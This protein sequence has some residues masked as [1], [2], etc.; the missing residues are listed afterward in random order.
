MNILGIHFGHDAGVCVLVPGKRP[1]AVGLERLDRIKYSGSYTRGWRNHF[2][3]NLLLLVDYCI[4]GAELACEDSKFDYIIYTKPP[5]EDIAFRSLLSPYTKP[6]TLFSR[7]NH[8]IAHACS[9][10]FASPFDDAAV[11]VVDG[12]G[13][14]PDGNLYVSDLAEKQ[15]FYRGTGNEIIEIKKSYG[16]PDYPFGLGEAYEIVTYLLGFGPFEAGKTMGLAPY[17]NGHM[18]K[19]FAIFRR[20]D[21]G[22]I[23]MDRDFFHWSE[24]SKWGDDYDFDTSWE[25]IRQLPSKFGC[26]RKP[27]DPLPQDFYNE[28]AYKIQI[29]LEEAMLELASHL[30]GITRSE[31]LCI[32]GGVGLNSITN[33]RIWDE[34]PFKNLFIQP[35]S[36]DTGL[37]LG[38]ALYGKH[39]LCGQQ[40]RWVMSNAYLGREYSE[41]EVTAAISRF[42]NIKVDYYG[43]NKLNQYF[44]EITPIYLKTAQLLANGMI[45]GWFQG[46]S[47]IGPRALGHRS[48]LAD[49]REARFRDILNSRVKHREGFRPFA[50]SILLEYAN[51]YFCLDHPS[52]FMILVAKTKAGKASEIP[53][54]THVDGTGRVQTV[55]L[56]END[57]YYH[58][59][60]E[61]HR[62]T[63]IP[64]ILN[65]SFNLKGEPIVETPVDALDSFL[66]TEMDYLVIHNYLIRKNG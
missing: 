10:F 53:A 13:D 58:L 25:I 28:M 63:G 16:S 27:Q 41:E 45:V 36:S 23:L 49:S 18:F 8:H 15:S 48:I 22:E 55:T 5:V 20:F 3:D 42:D 65:T 57:I 50:P 29:E 11:L 37:A 62:I 33:K 17:G 44:C 24:Y 47:E 14:R 32:A 31:N 43:P 2:P 30:Y 54:V 19:D 4:K 7:V 9:A 60:K 35:A 12:E 34:G 59:I 40:D 6:E 56:D 66:R 46:A 51:E 61:F 52:P 1:M 26:V 39:I 64:V 38:A 21:G